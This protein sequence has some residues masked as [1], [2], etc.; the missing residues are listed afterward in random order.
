M[1]DTIWTM[2]AGLTAFSFL[3]R[4]VCGALIFGAAGFLALGYGPDFAQRRVQLAKQTGA[5]I[6][7]TGDRNIQNNYFGTSQPHQRPNL[8]HAQIRPL[9][10]I[11]TEDVINLLPLFPLK[12]NT[13]PYGLA[14]LGRAG[15]AWPNS[16]PAYPREIYECVVTYYGDTPVLNARI[17][18]DVR[19]RKAVKQPGGGLQTGD[20]TF[21]AEWPIDIPRL[22]A[23]E[24]RPFRFFLYNTSHDF[25]EVSL[26]DT[27]SIQRTDQADRIFSKLV[28][29]EPAR[30]AVLAPFDRR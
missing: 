6:Q 22:E 25:A 21:S 29:P 30:P 13:R 23:G 20:S 14:Q 26:T 2:L 4:A 17:I 3:A 27:A 11:I 28:Q 12:G 18:L 19:F 16:D 5:A 9:T 15:R 10:S 8:I 24:Q 1:L 7:Q